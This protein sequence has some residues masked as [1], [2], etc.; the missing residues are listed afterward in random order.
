MFC[1]QCE[2]TAKGVGCTYLGVCSKTPEAS[3]TMD[4]II[5]ILRGNAKVAL[6]A[7]KK[8]VI[9]KEY[10]HLTIQAL[11][12]TLTNVNFDKVKLKE[13]AQDLINKRKLLMEK[14]GMKGV[15]ESTDIEDTEAFIQK[16]MDDHP[17][18]FNANED[19]QSLMQI[20]I[21]GLKGV[22]AYACHAYAIGYYKPEMFEGIYNALV[23]GYDGKERTLQEWIDLALAVGKT[24]FE[25]MGLLDEANNTYGHPEPTKV[26]IGHK[27]GKAILIT[28][29]DLKDLELLL[30]QTKDTGINVYTHG[31]MLPCHGY[32]QL[33]KYPHL[34]GHFGT[35]WN[36]QQ[37]EFPNFPGPILFT[38]NCLMKPLDS[39]KDHV[40]TTNEVGY[41]GLVHL[42]EKDF[43]PVIECAMKMQ[44]Y[45]D[46]VV[47]D[48]IMTGFAHHFLLETDVTAKL[49]DL[50]KANKIRD[51]YVI[52]GCDGVRQSRSYYTEIVQKLP[53]DAIVLT[54][55]CGK[56][57]FY[58]EKLGDI[59]G[60]PRLLD[61]GQ[62]NDSFS[63]ITVAVK[64]AEVF[65]C[66][67]NDLPVHIILSWYE[68]KAVAVLLALLHL[69]VKNVA[70][71]PTA[72]AFYS[73]G[74]FEYLN[75]NL[76]LRLI[77]T[78]DED[79]VHH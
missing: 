38:T 26:M 54:C 1:N 33:K 76:G 27:K 14:I 19:I 43:K 60:I 79:I 50:I 30:E 65:G 70:I 4:S 63:A 59:E 55:G 40:F 10:D 35:A 8:N 49:I 18:T 24:S 2:Q 68:Q 11:F 61:L 73:K 17:N 37:K 77:T 42:K 15:K 16:H 20:I 22:A 51:V 28:G 52:G 32:P 57:R 45:E 9:D 74:V 56:Y 72:P 44:G 7:R 64:L 75:K 47:E 12:T 3:N 34:V 48:E 71:G 6:E 31:E 41:E 58:R 25:V 53:K 46:D 13:L 39:Y 67:V 78:P 69:G 29:H 23:A 62:C 5:Y 66:G 21:L 36:N